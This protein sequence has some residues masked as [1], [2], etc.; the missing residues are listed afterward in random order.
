MKLILTTAAAALALTACSPAPS[1]NEAAANAVPPVA[2]PVASPT[3]APR[4]S[5]T[6][7]VLALEGLGALR[8]GQPVPK[9]SGWASRGAQ[10]SDACTTVTSPDNP[11]VYAIVEQGKV[12]RITVGQRSNVK[13][14]EGIGV[15]ASEKQ[16]TAAFPGFRATPHKYEAA[17]AKY[18]TAPGADGGDPA[19]RFEIGADGKV[20][21]IHVG[22]APA[23][24]Y[25]EGCA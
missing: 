13:L 10:V 8:I 12:R 16:V 17:P 9:D 19:L 18:L 1:G 5:P 14:I 11:G 2:T 4:V 6:A 7:D 22:T 21:A 3:P 23:L 25:V 20:S 24:F 15:G